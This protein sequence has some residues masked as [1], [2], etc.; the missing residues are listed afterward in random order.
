MS[1]FVFRD[2]FSVAVATQSVVAV[3]CMFCVASLVVNSSSPSDATNRE[4]PVSD[5]VRAWNVDDDAL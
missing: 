2:W 3:A 4:M 1:R 5:V